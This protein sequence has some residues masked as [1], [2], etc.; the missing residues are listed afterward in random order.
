MRIILSIVLFTLFAGTAN[1]SIVFA[2]FGFNQEASAFASGSAGFSISGNVL[3][4]VL[5]NTTASRTT[6]QGNALTGVAFDIKGPSGPL[7]LTSCGLTDATDKIWTSK[8]GSNDVNPLSGSWTTKL[9]SSPI[10]EYGVATTGFNGRFKA[11][12]ISRGN[13]SPDYG[14]VADGT[15]NGTNLAFGGSKFPFVQ[16]SLTFS[17]S[18]ASGLDEN[19]ITNVILLFGTSGTGIISAIPQA[20]PPASVPTPEPATLTIW[21]LGALGCA[22]AAYRRRKID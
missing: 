21:G 6:A 7:T 4:L 14:I 11:S 13:A 2:G 5:T 19:K 17:L 20:P 1:A 16:N 3:T 9:G 10:G 15:F 8:V 22:V 18:G 12:S